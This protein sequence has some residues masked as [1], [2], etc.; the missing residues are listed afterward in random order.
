[1]VEVLKKGHALNPKV[2]VQCTNCAAQLRYDKSEGRRVSDQRD[3]DAYVF[4]CPECHHDNWI[5]ASLVD[6]RRS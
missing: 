6:R 5:D 2:D 1:M 3:G 4:K